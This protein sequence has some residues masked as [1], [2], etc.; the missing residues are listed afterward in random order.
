MAAWWTKAIEDGRRGAKAGDGGSHGRRLE[1]TVCAAGQ[2]TKEAT[3]MG[4]I[5][6]RHSAPKQTSTD[7]TKAS[8]KTALR[9]KAAAA[10]NTSPR[11]P[12]PQKAVA[13]RAPAKPVAP[14]RVAAGK[15]RQPKSNSNG[16]S[17]GARGQGRSTK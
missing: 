10:Q 8:I 17:E 4:R 2:A 6:A 7:G 5:S 12:V 14:E 9:Q 13:A 3:V 16:E 1:D 15:Q 11:S